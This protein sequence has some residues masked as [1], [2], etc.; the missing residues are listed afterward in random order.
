MVLTRTVRAL[1][2]LL[3]GLAGVLAPA[4]AALAAP[5][6]R[7]DTSDFSFASFDAV[8]D[9]SADEDGRS[10]LRTTETLVA[11]F[12]DVDQNRGIRRAIP[13]DYDGHPTELRL[14]SVTD[15]TGAAREYET[16]E[17]DGYLV[18][19]IADDEYVHGAQTYVLSYEQQH[20]TH[21]P[22]DAEID[23]F[24]W[25][26]NGVG[27]D[28]PFGV[29]TAELRV[30]PALSDRFAG[31]AACYRG[32]AGSTESC[33]AI[34]AGGTP[35]VVRAEAADLGPRENLTIAVAFEPGTF[36]PRDDRFLSSPAA[37]LGAIGALLAVAAAAVGLALRFTRWRSHPGRGIVV[38]QYEPPRGVTVMEAAEL[39][40]HPDRAVTAT[41]LGLA[42]DGE[43]RVIET[44]SKKSGSTFAVES[45]PAGPDANGRVDADGRELA[46]LL[47]PDGT[48]GERRDLATRDTALA[49]KLYALRTGVPK[50]VVAKGWRTTPDG[51]LRAVLAIVAVAGGVASLVFGIFALTAAMGGAWPLVALIVG[52]IAAV[53]GVGAVAVVR[54]FTESGRAVRDHLEGL[55]EYIGLAEAD[56]LR[57]LQSP[58]G[59]LRTDT[60]VLRLTE[61]LLPYAVLFGLEREWSGVLAALYDERGETPGWYAGTDGFSAVAFVSGVHSF[62]SSATAS[63]SGSSSSSSSSSSGG[64]GASG[65]GGG[66]G[67]GGGV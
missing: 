35:L 22:D 53:V 48:A 12:P 62:S 24:A 10:V 2:A 40:G 42:V 54:P 41:L 50:R 13:L 29:V 11:E 45:T 4:G 37:I 32:P 66:G 25:D 6:A 57:M 34:E 59:A 58:S 8:Y 33:D 47:F 26:V 17:D 44:A 5:A 15:E 23:E 38:A 31:Q 65:G 49:R 56:R 43:L 63:W 52:L 61:R 67:G 64:G 39:T 28:Q 3:L 27:W 51:G 9:L 30:D 20:V 14:I 60:A 19:T 7:A 16:D 1:I 21:V 46:R 36:T 55:R 18:V